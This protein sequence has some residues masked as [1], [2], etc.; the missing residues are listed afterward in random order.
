MLYTV[1]MLAGLNGIYLLPQCITCQ[2]LFL[3]MYIS[4]TMK[5]LQRVKYFTILLYNMPQNAFQYRII[6]TDF[7]AFYILCY[8]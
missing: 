3:N 2:A 6:N 4:K 1:Y 5:T 7:T 8:L